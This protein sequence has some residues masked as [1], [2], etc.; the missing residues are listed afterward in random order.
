[1]AEVVHAR[2]KGDTRTVLAA[3]LKQP[4]E[5]GVNVAIDLS[6]LTV[7]FSMCDSDG[8]DAIGKT[9]SGVSVTTAS[10]GE[11]EYQF[12]AGG[13]DTVGKFY[14]SFIVSDGGA[15]DYFPVKPRELVISI[16]DYA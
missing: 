15:E 16:A 4:N 5:S 12:S 11:I 8:Q 3:T 6:G 2:H 9:E 13:V 14:G 1:M 7:E 10:S